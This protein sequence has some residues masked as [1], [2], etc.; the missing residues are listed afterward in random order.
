[1][2]GSASRLSELPDRENF[3]ILLKNPE[4]MTSIARRTLVSQLMET[5]IS[6]FFLIY[7]RSGKFV[8]K[9]LR[10]RDDAFDQQSLKRF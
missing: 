7:S 9:A 10:N 2:N 4:F 8:G 1:L 5:S 3:G 6:H